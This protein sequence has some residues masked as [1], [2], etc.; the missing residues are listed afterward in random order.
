MNNIEAMRYEQSAYQDFGYGNMVGSLVFKVA[1]IASA[2]YISL[3]ID[4]SD[5]LFG[6]ANDLIHGG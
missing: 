2:S 3:A 5:V 6:G 1:F 4:G